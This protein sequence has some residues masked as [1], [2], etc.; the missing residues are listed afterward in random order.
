MLVIFTWGILLSSYKEYWTFFWQELRTVDQPNFLGLLSHRQSSLQS[1][2]S[3]SLLLRQDPLVSLVNHPG[4]KQG[5]C[6]CSVRTWIPPTHV[7]FTTPCLFFA[8]LMA[9]YSTYAWCHM[10][11]LRDP[12]SG[13]SVLF[14]WTIPFFLALC[15]SYCYCISF[16]NFSSLSPQLI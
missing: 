4:I 8:L 10:P 14:L 3:L 1:R 16:F 2:A 15:P 13:V 7:K 12:I 11:E 5:R 9:F 6:L